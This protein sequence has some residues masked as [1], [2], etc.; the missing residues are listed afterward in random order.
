MTEAS[1]NY[2]GPM[3]GGFIRRYLR[4]A[5]PDPDLDS[6]FVMSSDRQNA[7]PGQVQLPVGRW[8]L[9][10]LPERP[11]DE[12]EIPNTARLI[13]TD[14]L[15]TSNWANLLDVMGL[16]LGNVDDMADFIVSD[17][18]IRGTWRS[19]RNDKRDHIIGYHIFCSLPVVQRITFTALQ[20][21]YHTVTNRGYQDRLSNNQN[22]DFRWINNTNP[23]APR[24]WEKR[25]TVKYDPSTMGVKTEIVFEFDGVEFYFGM[26]GY[27]AERNFL[28]GRHFQVSDVVFVLSPVWCLRDHVRF[29]D[30][31]E[32]DFGNSLRR[33]GVPTDGG[34]PYH[35][36]YDQ[37]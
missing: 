30:E 25:V 17:T 3:S 1:E 6:L 32:C 9:L 8:Y 23:Q 36:R 24:F 22:V 7:H 5:P 16:Y 2:T 18:V 29:S 12:G 10:G 35:R 11:R 13:R 14:H 19:N 21:Y 33:M 37:Y 15:F 26:C 28:M 31:V 20:L 27:T 34:N 4:I